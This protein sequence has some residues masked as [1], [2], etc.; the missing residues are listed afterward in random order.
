MDYPKGKL[1]KVAGLDKPLFGLRRAVPDF[2]AARAECFGETAHDDPGHAELSGLPGSPLFYPA[3][4]EVRHRATGRQIKPSRRS[5]SLRRLNMATHP[6]PLPSQKSLRLATALNVFLPAGVVYLGQR[7]VGTFWL[8]A[9]LACF[10]LIRSVFGRFTP[11]PSIAMS[12]N[13]LEET[14]WRR[15]ERISSE[16]AARPGRRWRGPVSLLDGVV[17]LAKRRIKT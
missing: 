3:K 14:S 9:F 1:E 5:Q 2:G 7:A 11:L 4:A 16:L 12:E 15:P 13:L 6:P 10:R 17:H 8:G